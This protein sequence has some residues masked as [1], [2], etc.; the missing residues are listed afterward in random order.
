MTLAQAEDAG[1]VEVM[2]DAGRTVFLVHKPMD[3][4]VA[5]GSGTLQ[6]APITGEGKRGAATVY[7]LS[8][9]PLDVQARGAKAAAYSGG[10]AVSGRPGDRKAPRTTLKRRGGKLVA[11]AKDDTGVAVTMV[12]VGKRAKPYKRALRARRGSVVRYWSVDKA[13]NRERKHRLVVR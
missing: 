11:K 9:G 10:R 13:G 5:A 6:T 1:L 7:D 4:H 8:A 2:R 12:Q 3:V